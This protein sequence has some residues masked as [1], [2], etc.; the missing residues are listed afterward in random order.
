[1]DRRSKAVLSLSIVVTL[2]LIV[3]V[4]AMAKGRPT[5][6]ATNNLSVPTIMLADGSF[7]NVVC[8]EDEMSV[9][10]PPTGTALAGYPISPLDYYY[11]QGVHQWQAPCNSSTAVDLPVTA[12][13]GDN[14]SGDAKLKVGSPIRVELGLF[15]AGSVEGYEV[16]KLDSSALDR[17]APYGTLAT[18][19]GVSA[20]TANPKVF[21]TL[22]VFD[23]AVTFSIQNLD[24]LA[25]VVQA[26]T[27]ASAEINATG[28]VVY[29]YNLRVPTAGQYRI[30]YTVPTA[31]VTLADAGLWTEHSVSLDIT[32][33]SGG[34]GGGGKPTRP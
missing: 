11:V 13:W 26:G 4:G 17:E 23:T 21:T 16:I 27:D 8:G 22:R 9:L 25:Y 5:I 32:V 28:N 24:T 14:L 19:D 29:G 6:E 3:P 10:D 34:G 30:T 2:A 18:Y 1:M 12:G 20:F 33:G 7:T 15:T 31:V